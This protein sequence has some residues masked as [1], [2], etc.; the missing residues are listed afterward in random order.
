MNASDGTA[1]DGVSHGA[2]LKSAPG[3]D[4]TLIA[5][6]LGRD[7]GALKT[8][9]DKYSNLVYSVAL[10]TLGETTAAEDVLQEIFLQL[11]TKPSSFD[12]RR[13]SLPAWL[14]VLA[15]N[16]SIDLRRKRRPEVDVEELPLSSSLDLEDESIRQAI[17][18]KARACMADFPPEQRRDVEMAFFEG[19]THAEI[20]EKTA[21]PLGTVKTRIRT[22]LIALRRALA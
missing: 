15:R 21:Q 11:W 16:R 22:G 17:A 1:V 3:D 20:A 4:A 10:R 8:L 5:S 14:S 13:G 12:P 19:L 2:P 7:G 6:L 18:S 9:Y